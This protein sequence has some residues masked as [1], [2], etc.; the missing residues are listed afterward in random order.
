MDYKRYI[1]HFSAIVI[2]VI[3]T[4]IF[5]SPLFDGKRV[6]Q[7]DVTMYLGM[8][9]EIKDFRDVTGEEALWTNSMFG[10]M[11]AFQ[12][13]IEYPSNLVSY[14]QKFFIKIFPFPATAILLC[15]I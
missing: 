9:K 4:A 1:P 2:F 12:I 3:I 11:P 7:H 13:S 15:M 10:G 6:K 5:F 8:S 14:I